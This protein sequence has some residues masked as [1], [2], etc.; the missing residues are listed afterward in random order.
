MMSF[1]MAMASAVTI[2]PAISSLSI[3]C[4]TAFISLTFLLTGLCSQRYACVERGKPTRYQD[5]ARSPEL[6]PA[7]PCRQH[8][9]SPAR[10]G[11]ATGHGN[12]STNSCILSAMAQSL[13]PLS[14]RQKGR[15]GRHPIFNIPILRNLL[16][17]CLPKAII[18]ARPTNPESTA[19]YHQHYDITESVTVVSFACSAE[20]GH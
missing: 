10:I 3:S 6:C 5:F 8:R 4:G 2:F 19:K 15:F 14:T 17:L 18:S 7:R 12:T 1:C 13:M 9:L 16:I 20:I 11:S